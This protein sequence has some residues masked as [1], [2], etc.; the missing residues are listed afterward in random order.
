MSQLSVSTTDVAKEHHILKSIAFDSLPARHSAVRE[1]HR[2]TFEWVFKEDSHNTSTRTVTGCGNLIAW[3]K[4]GN[5]TFWI[6]GKPGSGKSTLMK[7]I[8]DHDSTVQALTAWSHPHPPVIARHYFWSAGTSMQKSLQGLLQTL[9]FDIF[10]QQSDLI[11]LA[12]AER[13]PEP[14]EVLKLKPWKVPELHRILQKIGGWESLRVK[15]CFFIDGLDEYEGDHVDFCKILKDLSASPNLKL[16]ISSRPWNVF[17][18]SFGRS[19]SSKL[20]VHELTRSDIRSY[21]EQR[22]HEHPR[23]HDLEVPPELSTWLV[24]QITE[25][26]AGVFL[27]V[28]LVTRELRSGLTEYDSFSDLQRRLEAIPTD[29]GVFFRQILESV[30]PF[31]HGKMATTLLMALAARRSAS[32]ELYSFQDLEHEDEHYALR[33]PIQHLG[34]QEASVRQQKVSRQLRGRCRGLLEVDST[35]RRVEFLHRTVVDFL[36]TSEMTN[37]LREKSASGFNASLALLRAYIA[38]IKTTQY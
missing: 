19:D 34:D 12:C 29:L 18:D 36:R 2:E 38:C 4:H 22:L 6:S 3:L 15:M 13:W 27:W 31:Y 32:V 26:A 5:G 24:D 9:L 28:F 20:Y 7:F 30:E 35:T 25:R 16:C 1:A 23:W 17:E 21:A 14:P 11:E 33:M 10:R 37:F 8:A